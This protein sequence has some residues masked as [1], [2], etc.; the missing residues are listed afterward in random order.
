MRPEDIDKL[1]GDRLKNSAPT[2]PADLWNRL[3]E[4]IE[5]EMPETRL[6]IKPEQEEKK[7]G[8]MWVYSS[9]AATLSLLLATGLVFYNL[10]TSTPEVQEILAAK[11]EPVLVEEPFYTQPAPTETAI[12]AQAEKNSEK[13][14]E[15]QATE[16]ATLASNNTEAVTKTESPVAKAETRK[17][18][19]KPTL[20]SATI[21]STGTKYKTSDTAT[22][23]AAV[24]APEVEPVTPA[25]TLAAAE[26]AP[27]NL[28][29]APVEI[30]I[31]RAVAQQAAPA[32][33]Q[34]PTGFDK[35]KTLAKNIFKQVR[36]LSNGEPVELASIV[37]ADKISLNTQIG[38]QK[39]TKVIQL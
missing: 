15:A 1:F 17:A 13:N 21:A 14:R 7:K 33:T 27:A 22:Q 3:Q 35:K 31:T 25:A 8:F 12:L 4:R 28:N 20:K 26:V 32:E 11:E 2:P 30:T 24:T 19:M 18:S 39:F 36:N 34:E 6:Q 23:P 5:T 10:K 38:K 37:R 9:V 16:P 29:A